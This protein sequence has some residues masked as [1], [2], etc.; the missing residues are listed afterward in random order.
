MY[1]ILYAE[2]NFENYKLVEFVLNK[3]GFDVKNAVDGLDVID[4]IESYKP[5]LIIM[6]IDIPN[7]NGY[8]VTSWLKSKEAYKDIPVVALTADYNDN[9]EIISKMSGCVAYY[10]KPVDSFSFGREIKKLI[11]TRQENCG[12][13]T[14]SD[15]ISKS[16]VD[17]SLI[18]I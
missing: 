6:D 7:L 15:Q 12:T 2:D 3:N 4:K 5:H 1:R 18:H 16:L 11:E 14:L 8:E 17:L 10:S 9:F 13:D